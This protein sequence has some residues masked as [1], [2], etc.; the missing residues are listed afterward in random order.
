MHNFL[1]KF[2][3]DNILNNELKDITYRYKELILDIEDFINKLKEN[4]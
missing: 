1:F 3:V 2:N 4:K